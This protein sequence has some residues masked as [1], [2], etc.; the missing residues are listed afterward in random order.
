M[1]R[2]NR[3]VRLVSILVLGGL[4]LG[5]CL[6]A[7]APGVAK[8]AASAQYSGKVGPQ[9]RSLED[10]TTLYDMNGVIY[11]RLGDLDRQPVALSAVPRVLRRAVIATE[12]RTFY[13][14]DG[15]DVRSAVR[16]FASNVGSGGIEQGG[17]TIT[18]QLIKN[19]FF[20]NPKRSLDRKIREAIL[21]HRLTNEWSK[22]RIL[23]EYLN[24]VYFGEN[25]YGVQAASTRII[26]K[27]NLADLTLP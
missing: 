10:P 6:V 26:G 25:S 22:D 4:G 5:V 17:S 16:A 3:L 20:K 11:D 9:L 12:D 2:W 24:T 7:L 27:S 1:H 8:I 21:A 19:R 23:E 18:Q 13:T 14:N 15:I